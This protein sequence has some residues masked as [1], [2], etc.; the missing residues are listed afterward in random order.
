MFDLFMRLE[1]DI[2]STDTNSVRRLF[3][4]SEHLGISQ[5][6]FELWPKFQRK[7]FHTPFL[8]I[9]NICAF[10]NSDCSLL[11]ASYEFPEMTEPYSEPFQAFK[12]KFFAKTINVWRPLVIF[13]KNSILDVWDGFE[14]ASA[15]YEVESCIELA[16]VNWLFLN[17]P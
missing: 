17:Y 14:Y 13:A 6:Y 11:Q 7:H 8:K 1:K 5:W 2:L 10:T 3:I 15:W 16:F 4:S 12:M 9:R